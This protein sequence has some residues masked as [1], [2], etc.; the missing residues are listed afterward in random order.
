[1]TSGQTMQTP[2]G[3]GENKTEW[4]GLKN[5]PWRIASELGYF[6]QYV[7]RFVTNEALTC[8][9]RRRTFPPR[10]GAATRT[11]RSPARWSSSTGRRSCEP[12]VEA[13]VTSSKKWR[14][15]RFDFLEPMNGS[16]GASVKFNHFRA[17]MTNQGREIQLETNIQTDSIFEARLSST[18]VSK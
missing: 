13:K 11:S 14:C 17:T 2:K 9:A 15:G 18:A 8:W 6:Y 4:L 3:R 1:M 10:P 12:E 16:T 7:P 5:L